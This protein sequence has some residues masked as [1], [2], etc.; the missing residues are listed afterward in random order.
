VGVGVGGIYSCF[1]R[2]FRVAQFFRSSD[3]YIYYPRRLGGGSKRLFRKVGNTS[4]KFYPDVSTIRTSGSY[5]YEAFLMTQGTDIKIYVVGPDYAHAEAR[6]S[7]VVDGIVQRD[8]EG[9]EIRFPIMLTNKEKDIARR[10]CLAFR[11]N[12]CGFDLL[13]T[14][15]RS[16]VCDVNGWS[17][18]C[19][20]LPS[21]LA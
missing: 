12:V 4:S 6:K 8:K 7:P 5:I 16:Y 19:E 13:R 17:S 1:V 11:Q 15:G 18:T 21:L 10:V 2:S 20:S 14:P 9:K 3:I